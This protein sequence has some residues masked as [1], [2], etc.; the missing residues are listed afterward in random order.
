MRLLM[1][2]TAL[3]S[4][5]PCQAGAFETAFG[6]QAMLYVHV[7]L[8]ARQD[9]GSGTTFGLRL[10]NVARRADRR[11]EFSG[12]PHTP[13]LL[14]FRLSRRGMDGIYI[15]GRDYLEAYRIL[16]QNEGEQGIYDDQTTVGDSVR[17]IISDMT[18]VAPMG[19]WIG[20]GLGIGLM[21]GVGD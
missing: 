9:A 20:A 8:D 2:L 11:I 4:M 17:G 3:L 16:R 13:A 12:I 19:I 14:D 5:V 21:M 6:S 1:I 15:S 7:P 18:S 10:D